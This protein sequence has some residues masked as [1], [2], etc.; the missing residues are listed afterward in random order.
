MPVEQAP[1]EG[2]G[3]IG[4]KSVFRQVAFQQPDAADG[5]RAPE[6][7]AAE[8]T[9][10]ETAAVGEPD[11]SGK[12]AVEA[13]SPA[14]EEPAAAEDPNQ[15]EALEAVQDK[16]RDQIAKQKATA[17][18]DNI[19]KAVASDLTNYAE[20]LALWQA[21]GGDKPSPPDFDV[22]ARVQ[23]VEA[24][25]TGLIEVDEA[26]DAGGIG[27]SFEFI[28]DPGSRFGIRQQ[29]WVEMVYGQGAVSLRPILSRDMAGNR[30][31]SWKTED[32]LEETPKFETALPNV[33]QAWRII[34]GRE[35]AR[36][37]AEGIA[38]KSRSADS[39]AAAVAGDDSLQALKAGPFFWVAPQ[40]LTSGVA[41]ISQPAGVVMPGEEFMQAVFSVPP[42]GTVVAFNEPKTVA[43]CIRLIDL[44]PS[45]EV[46]KG[47]FLEQRADQRRIGVVAQ[48]QFSRARGEW[49][50]GLEKRYNLEWKRL[51][52]R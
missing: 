9:S 3:E 22:I 13:T 16:I 15:F 34:E 28:P 12:L 7:P 4:T 42:G 23:G 51:P 27:Q 11:P 2:S 31:L 47:K 44:E 19:F 5:D 36:K 33:Q 17:R 30:Y 48:S 39:L 50:E 45:T 43:Y 49:F 8:S 35:L 29:N 32:Q 25:K 38:E 1:P 26:V 41:Q 24:G 10:T 6:T 14:S 21:R 37:R 20:D 18:I 46:L 52:R 40:G